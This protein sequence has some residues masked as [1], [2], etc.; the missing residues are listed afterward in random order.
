LSTHSAAGIVVKYGEIFLKKGRRRYFLDV[1]AANLQHKLSRIGP[2][3]KL[4]R[5]YSRF[6]IVPKDESRRIDDA[7]SV[8]AAIAQVFGVVGVSPC[9]I[10][11]D[12]GVEQLEAAV[13][14]YAKFVRRRAHKTFKIETRRADKRFPMTSIDCNRHFGSVVWKALGDVEVDIHNPDLTIHIEIREEFTFI[15]SNATPAV[16]GLPV[17]S[18]GKALLLL[19]GGIDSPVAGWLTMKRGVAIDSITFLSPPYTGPKARDKVEQ[20]AAKLASFQ[21]RST[22]WVVPFAAI[23]EHYRDNAP[24]PLLVLLYRR[25]M[26]RI[27]DA[28]A[29]REGQSALITG[30]SLGQVASQTIPNL[31]C[32]AIVAKRPVFRPLITYDKLEAVRLGQKIGTYETSIQPYDDCCS[33]FVPNHPELKG[34]PERLEEVEQKVAPWDLEKQAF[35]MAERIDLKG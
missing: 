30:E 22:L 5:P 24:G 26:F 29:D 10:V 11:R 33:L 21:R 32:I 23:Q 13:A 25:S 20:L 9:E 6:L 7:E 2:D 27:A 28:I 31:H 19:S 18:N 15:T 34:R 17:G 14:D 1:L 8:A 4:L 12:G 16:G 35:E 3:L